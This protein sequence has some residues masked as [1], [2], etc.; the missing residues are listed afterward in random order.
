MKSSTCGYYGWSGTKD[1]LEEGVMQYSLRTEKI[2][3]ERKGPCY[4]KP[5]CGR[6]THHV[7]NTPYNRVRNITNRLGLVWRLYLFNLIEGSSVAKPFI[8]AYLLHEDP[9]KF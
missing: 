1:G 9:P 6:L 7:C 4:L 2:F 3:E 5:T 8:V